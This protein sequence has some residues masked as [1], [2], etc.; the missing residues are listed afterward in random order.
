MKLKK[1]RNDYLIIPENEYDIFKLGV[2]ASRLDY[3]DRVIFSTEKGKAPK[4]EGLPVYDWELLEDLT[5][6]RKS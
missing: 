3:W 6:L 1:Q 4:M 2:L 5:L